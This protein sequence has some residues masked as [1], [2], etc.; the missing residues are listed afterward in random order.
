LR[1]AE[2]GINKAKRG[3]GIFLVTK[4]AAAQPP[5]SAAISSIEHTSMAIRQISE[6]APS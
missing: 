4:P 3:L 2:F 6:K 1:S 5:T